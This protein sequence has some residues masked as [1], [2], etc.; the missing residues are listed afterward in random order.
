M[1][2]HEH[3]DACTPDNCFREK[4]RYIRRDGGLRTQIGRGTSP[5]S[6]HLSPRELFHESTLA[7]EARKLKAQNDAVGNEIEKKSTRRELI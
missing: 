3:T 1:A 5:A 6:P 4:M 7:N 2:D